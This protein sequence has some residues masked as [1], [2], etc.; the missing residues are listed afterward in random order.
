MA[1]DHFSGRSRA[2]PPAGAGGGA[3][4]GA[5]VAAAAVL[6]LG[7]C[8]GRVGEPAAG[9]A[10]VT[11]EPATPLRLAQTSQAL[12][13]P[14]GAV[15][16]EGSP[17]GS[18]LAGRHAHLEN[19]APSA[20]RFYLRSLEADP[21]NPELLNRALMGAL[22]VR[23]LDLGTE[24]ARRLLEVDPESPVAA[25]ALAVDAV[26]DG[27]YE[28]AAGWL[29]KMP[30]S[31]FNQYLV[32]LLRAWTWVGR[33]DADQALAAL[34]PLSANSVF[35]GTH[36]YHSGLIGEIFGRSQ[37]AE[38]GY[39]SA[40][41][42]SPGGPLRVVQAAGGFYQRTGR[43]DEARAIYDA[44]LDQ[45]PDTTFLDAAYRA[46]E[47]GAPPPLPVTSANEGFA[48]ALYGI[49]ISLF[50][51]NAL[52]P[53][54]VYGQLAL[55]LRPGLDVGAMLLGDIL[56]TVGQTDAA[57][58]AYRQVPS[59]SGLAWSVRLRIANAL[60][61][62]DKIDEAA[63][64]FRA[65]ARERPERPD[66]LIQLADLMRREERYA[67]A[68]TAYDQA[69]A[70]IPTLEQRHWTLLYARGMS[71]ERAHQWQRAERDLQQ[72]LELE[73]DQPLV[74]NYLGYSWVE[75]GIKLDAAKAMIEKAAEQRPNDGYIVD[76]LGW[77]LYRLGEYERAVGHLERAA[78]LRP[79]DPVILDHY[80]DGL[81]RVGR[82]AEARF[83]WRRA[84]SFQP[85]PELGEALDEKLSKGLGPP[86]EIT[87]DM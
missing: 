22:A 29:D 14:P 18:Y 84:L 75:M 10:E 69:F 58:A 28:D 31:G 57:V 2:S 53:A 20:L 9:P 11:A 36:D 24:L 37:A 25:L 13:L 64:E 76:S 40:L 79:M 26:G 1:V 63:E 71:L 87:K 12:D 67:D 61:S 7:A 41:S 68:V 50:Q 23:D 44:F 8:A 43:L 6:I 17:L 5:L 48:E 3:R 32:P 60:A 81:W 62:S 83:Q 16:G 45:N 54:L 47:A 55:Y 46:L 80:G 27:A 78:E 38:N 59:E 42:G 39:A 72:A 49:A 35:A 30:G 77:V 85:E 15:D 86:T 21:D 56:I 73:P 66:P 19:D 51:E 4:Q 34:E 52:E 70:R 74:L 33:A 82:K 65:M